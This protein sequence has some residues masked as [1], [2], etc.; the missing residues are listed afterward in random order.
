MHAKRQQIESDDRSVCVCVCERSLHE[1]HIIVWT[2]KNSHRGHEIVIIRWDFT[3]IRLGLDKSLC[4]RFS[5][6]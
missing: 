6:L 4:D 5:A 1:L 2:E 3:N